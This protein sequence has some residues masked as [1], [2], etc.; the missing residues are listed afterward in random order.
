MMYGCILELYDK[1]FFTI[2]EENGLLNNIE[3]CT[4]ENYAT[5]QEVEEV[6]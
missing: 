2:S 6:D 4:L 5:H 3:Q 1:I